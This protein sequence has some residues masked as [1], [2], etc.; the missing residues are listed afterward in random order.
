M[1]TI[2]QSIQT[3]PLNN[4]IILSSVFFVIGVLGVMLRRNAI[5]IFL[6]I[7]LMLKAVN[8]L[9]AAF[10]PFRGDAAV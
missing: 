5:I 10:S 7:E 4:Y 9:L 6:S 8:L 3:V 2:T 1:E